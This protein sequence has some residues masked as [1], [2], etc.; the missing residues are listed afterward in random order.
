MTTDQNQT[1]DDVPTSR[2]RDFIVMSAIASAG[3]GGA[4]MLNLTPSGAVR[5][6]TPG[7]HRERTLSRRGNGRLLTSMRRP[8]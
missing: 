4:S 2:S 6:E 8:R 5:R 7:G 1:T 3:V